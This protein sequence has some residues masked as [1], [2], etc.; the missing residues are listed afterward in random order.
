[1][2]IPQTTSTAA[3][4]T[5]T[6]HGYDRPPSDNG[7]QQ[8]RDV[9]WTFGQNLIDMMT[10]AE[11]EERWDVLGVGYIMKAWGWMA[12]TDLHGEIIIEQAFD[13]T[14]FSFDYDSQELAYQEILRLLD[15]AI[16]NLER[17]DG[18]V[19]AGYL[20]VGDKMYN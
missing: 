1:W 7:G 12:V 15:E 14:R 10:K 20:A 18:A 4:N 5:W 11:A 6:R 2:V 17:T 19:D 16:A 8:W 13:P 3:P 9:Y